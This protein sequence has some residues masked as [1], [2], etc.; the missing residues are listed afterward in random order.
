M[1]EA[2]LEAV[3]R[4]LGVTVVDARRQRL[5]RFRDDAPTSAPAAWILRIPAAPAGLQPREWQT[6]ET[7]WTDPVT[8]VELRSTAALHKL[9]VRWGRAPSAPRLSKRD[10]RTIVRHLFEHIESRELT[11]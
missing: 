6:G 1:A 7:G 8:A 5:L 10:G 11:A 2:P 3:S 9:A 4:L